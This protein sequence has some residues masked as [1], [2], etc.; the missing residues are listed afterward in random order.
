MQ[1]HQNNLGGNRVRSRRFRLRF[2]ESDQKTTVTLIIGIICRDGIVVASDSQTT[3]G[4]RK[5]NDTEKIDRVKFKNA[6][7]LIAQA[8]DTEWGTIVVEHVKD[9]AAQKEIDDRWAL[10]YM[11]DGQVD[12]LQ[13]RYMKGF[14]I[15]NPKSEDFKNTFEGH[16][17]SF[18]MAHYHDEKPFIFT[19]HFPGGRSSR[20]RTAR[21]AARARPTRTR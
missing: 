1:L 14:D 18:M 16:K 13:R 17:M 4:G 10:A 19:H 3:Y 8:G 5:R 15:L 11:V 21:A 2:P 20:R 6:E 9:E 12:A 7:A